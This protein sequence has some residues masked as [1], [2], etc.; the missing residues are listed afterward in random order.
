MEQRLAQMRA[1]L[2]E[3]LKAIK[4]AQKMLKRRNPDIE[5]VIDMLRK[6]GAL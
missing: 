3:K 1:P 6:I 2:E 4:K 5:E